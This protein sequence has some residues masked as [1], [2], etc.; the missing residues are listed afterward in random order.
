MDAKLVF[1]RCLAEFVGF[2]L[3][4]LV[5]RRVGGMGAKL[6]LNECP[7]EFARWLAGFVGTELW[8]AYW[9]S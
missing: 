5:S 3:G 1:D 4:W 9:M 6:I 2:C 8:L 7:E